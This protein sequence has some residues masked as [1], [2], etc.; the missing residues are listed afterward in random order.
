MRLGKDQEALILVVLGIADKAH[1]FCKISTLLLS[2]VV[3][4]KSKGEISWNFVAFSKYMN[5]NI[6]NMYFDGFVPVID[7]DY[8]FFYFSGMHIF[9]ICFS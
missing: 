9:I 1:I 6:P 2:Y 7:F 3:P 5:F 8:F 4:V